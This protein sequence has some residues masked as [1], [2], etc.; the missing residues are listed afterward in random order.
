M[1]HEEYETA[2]LCHVF[3]GCTSVVRGA[4]AR[5]AAVKI[6]WSS[7]DS[8]SACRCFAPTTKDG[9]YVA[10]TILTRASSSVLMQ[11]TILT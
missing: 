3:T 6:V 11:V 4:A 2:L 9:V 7:M 5:K 10:V 8:V 1:K